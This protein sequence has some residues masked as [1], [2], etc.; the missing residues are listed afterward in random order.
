MSRERPAELEAGYEA[1]RAEAVGGLPSET[2]RGRALLLAGGLPAWI[3]AWATPPAGPL[4][5]AG[6]E[7]TVT[8]G[9][10]SEVVRLLTEMAL[11]RRVAVAVR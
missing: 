3:R 10:G 6:S 8:G 7:R 9:L 11:G 1:L 5:A 4:P 2:P